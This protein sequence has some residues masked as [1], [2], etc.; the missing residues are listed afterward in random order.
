MDSIK[1]DCRHFDGSMPCPANKQRGYE[2]AICPEYE[3]TGENLLF[4]K[5]DA[6]G[7]VVRAG[8]LLPPLRKKHPGARIVWVTRSESTDVVHAFP[9]VDE[10]IAA[11]A[12][13][14]A[15]IGTR[16]WHHVYSLSNDL[17]SASIAM[18]AHALVSVHGFVLDADGKICPTNVAAERWLEMASFDRVKKENAR[19]YQSIMY[20]IA[21][22]DEP[23]HRPPLRLSQADLTHA[24]AEIRRQFG[25]G[26]G[27]L[28]GINVGSGSR[29]PKKMLSAG[30]IAECC[31]A[32]W[33]LRPEAKVL[34]LGGPAES[35][36]LARILTL[37]AGR[38]RMIGTAGPGQKIL[39]YAALISQCQALLTGDT[40]ALH[41]AT[42]FAVPTVAV[43]GPT[44]MAEIHP[45]D[46]TVVKLA[47]ELDCLCC[48]G[49]CDKTANCMTL[50]R[51]S[52]VAAEIARLL[53][54]PGDQRS[55]AA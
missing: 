19:S 49:N 24:R 33:K 34:L 52:R 41:F 55:Q 11:D 53:A 21:G 9:L 30:A 23:V 16:P 15:S 12:F 4:I 46:G 17:P 8:S 37:V 35:G 6:M 22:C 7:D 39:E 14:I 3:P 54:R 29:W 10:V 43:F 47:A 31:M 44:S 50:L 48:Y 13:G 26:I 32:L 36:K 25:D 45:Y 42:A 5:L 1:R 27:D 40:L 38:G 2:C 18:L 28:V 20:E 51:P